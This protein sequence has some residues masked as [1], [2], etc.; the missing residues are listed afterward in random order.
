MLAALLIPGIISGNTEDGTYYAQLDHVT[1]STT[2]LGVGF[3]TDY[4][5]KKILTVDFDSEQIDGGEIRV[6]IPSSDI[7]SGIIFLQDLDDFCYVMQCDDSQC[8]QIEDEY[9][10][11]K[12]SFTY[13]QST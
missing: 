5:T 10:E 13:P 8:L 11:N 3:N 7:F 6:T 1:T 4:L 2:S 9:F 12:P